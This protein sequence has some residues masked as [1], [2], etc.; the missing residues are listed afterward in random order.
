MDEVQ[1]KALLDKIGIVVDS[2]LSEYDKKAKEEAEAARKAEEEAKKKKAED[3]D[4]VK[5]AEKKVKEQKDAKNAEEL[6]K[7]RFMNAFKFAST[8]KDFLKDNKN[9]LPENLEAII[10]IL[11]AKTYGSD[12][13]K[14]TELK[15][16]I[17]EQYVKEQK[18]L[19]LLP[20]HLRSKAEKYAGFTT[21]EKMDS[22]ADYYDIVET[23][24]HTAKNIKKVEAVEKAGGLGDGEKTA[25]Q[26]YEEK[27][28]EYSKEAVD[29][30]KN[31]GK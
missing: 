6:E 25:V 27:M 11:E 20:D 1:M 2:K 16:A 18:N 17:I 22:A 7:M 21:K 10:N 28:L 5:A 8:V 23:G 19:D 3:D 12:I 4:A 29:G 30:S 15:R 26:D 9:F 24:I 31:D 14:E 13:E